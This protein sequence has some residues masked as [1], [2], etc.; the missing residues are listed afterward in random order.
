[1]RKEKSE[2]DAEAREDEIDGTDENADAATG[3]DDETDGSEVEIDDETDGETDDDDDSTDGGGVELDADEGAARGSGPPGREAERRITPEEGC[4]EEAARV[5]FFS[6]FNR[7]YNGIWLQER[8][9]RS[10]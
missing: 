7:L 2:A 8:R 3:S 1:M 5:N 6:G 4:N 9:A 10:T